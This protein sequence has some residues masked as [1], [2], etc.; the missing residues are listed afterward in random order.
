MAIQE[1]LPKVFLPITGVP[2]GGMC[3]YN[4]HSSL[5]E[6][7]DSSTECRLC[8]LEPWNTVCNVVEKWN[9]YNV[10]CKAENVNNVVNL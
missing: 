3:L 2:D 7:C 1:Q 5:P 6:R 10:L 9:A 4:L 8:R